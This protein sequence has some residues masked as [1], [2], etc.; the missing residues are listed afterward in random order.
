MSSHVDRLMNDPGTPRV[1][2]QFA[3]WSNRSRG[4]TSAAVRA[5]VFERVFNAT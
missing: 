1:L 3:G 4:E 5:N 2:D